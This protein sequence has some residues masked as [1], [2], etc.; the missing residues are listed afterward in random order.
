M[1]C[2]PRL[3]DPDLGFPYL[4]L[5]VSGGHC[6]LLEVR[7]VGD[8]RRLATTIDD[9]AGEAFDKAAK[10][11]GLPYPGG[12]AIEE[13]ARSGDPAAVPLPRPLMGSA[14]PHF[15]FAGLKSAVQ[16]AV[17]SAG[18]GAKTSPPASSRR[19][20]IASSTAPHLRW[21]KATRRRSSSPAES[22][23]IRRFAALWPI[24]RGAQGR[25]FSVPPA[26]LCTDNAAMIA[27]AGAERLAAG[28]DRPAGRSGAGALASRRECR[29]GARRR[30]QGMRIERLAVIGGG[31]WG[32]ALAQAVAADG[33]DTLLWALEKEVV[34]AVNADHCNPLYLPEIAL[35]PSISATSDLGELANCDAWLVV[36]PAQHMRSVLSQAP[37]AG[38][39]MVLCSKG[40]EERTGD[41]LHRVARTA[42]PGG[43]V[44][45]LSGPTFA[46]EVAAGLPTAVTLAC[47]DREIGEALRDRIGHQAFRTYL[48]DDVVGAEIGG[49]VKNVLAIAC[50][51]VEGAGL[52]Q[53]ARA[54]LIARGFIEMT[55][56]GVACG[57]R[58]ET[59]AGLSGLGDLVLTCTSTSSRNFSLGFGIGEGRS[60]AALLSDRRT[61]AEGAFTAPVLARIARE[62]GVDMPIVDAVERLLAG[63]AKVGEILG[64]FCSP[65]ARARLAPRRRADLGK[66]RGV[67]AREAALRML[68]GVLRRGQTLDAAASASRGL[69]PA[70]QALAV[71]IAGET[72]RRL[73]DLDAL[74]DGSTR[75]RLP[76]DAKARTVLR[77]ALA[78]K[79]GLGTPDH[80]VVA[81]ALPLVDGGPRRLVH[82]VLGNLLRK[83]VQ[84]TEESRLPES[85]EERWRA[86]WGDEVV[87]AARRQIVRRPPLDLSFTDDAEAQAYAAAH[88]GVSLAPRHVRLESSSVAE[89]AG[90]GEGRWWVQD[91][92][93][94]LPAR[95]IPADATD[96]LDLCA[97]P[98]G[99]TMQLAAAG[100]RVT[101]VDA[102][103]TRLERL[104]ENLQRTHLAAELVEADALK[105]NPKRQFDAIL[106][107]APCSATGTFRRHPEVLYRA[108]PSVIEENADFQAKLLGR[109]ARWLKPGGTLVYSVCSLEPDE[110][111]QIAGGSGAWQSRP[112]KAGELPDF[113]ASSPA[114]WVRILPGC[115]NL[116]AGSTA[117]SSPA[118]WRPPNPV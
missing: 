92:A 18:T 87:H 91:L 28:I 49:A 67:G 93:A 40:I 1:R 48:T 62:K 36:T 89:L 32:T 20:S 33:E 86:A 112:P 114:G 80:A 108:R 74:I 52:G 24:L 25:G 38:R 90:F 113:A 76:D 34:A 58:P 83:G 105:W 116:R 50:G 102:S 17:A 30:G 55:R 43:E 68:D 106:L 11:L 70:D 8:Y 85:V 110:G 46:H 61:V 94:S 81:T 53:N 23:R 117:S 5:L 64:E 97:A 37:R 73:P 6:Q 13:L 65:G 71:A 51:V 4:L 107:D 44:A 9:A 84:A 27:W 42:C 45:V 63:Q 96:V 12:P 99:K 101:S 47:E 26:W 16:R 77:L 79:I 69:P 3:A 95:L 66:G 57:A 41:L 14:E 104:R 29:E 118:L 21:A 115:S 88:H 82:G 2:R 19:W 111:E 109:A 15:S 75:Q 103:A 35:S 56:F 54:A 22:R 100:H 78:Q 60:A 7:G 10:L 72:L 31:A 39:P 98:G 59:L